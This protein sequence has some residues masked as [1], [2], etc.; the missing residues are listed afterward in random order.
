MV[1]CSM[2]NLDQD[3]VLQRTSAA[4]S[5]AKALGA[6]PERE[7][8]R[9][10]LCGSLSVS[11]DPLWVSLWLSL[12][13]MIYQDLRSLLGLWFHFVLHIHCLLGLVGQTCAGSRCCTPR[14]WPKPGMGIHLML[15]MG[16]TPGKFIS[17]QVPNCLPI[18]VWKDPF[19]S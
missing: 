6:N 18:Q 13:I 12:A 16:L 8:A 15:I 7:R 2:F 14:S 1:N 5:R 3:K 17:S 4:G 19:S 11:L 9:Q 10:N